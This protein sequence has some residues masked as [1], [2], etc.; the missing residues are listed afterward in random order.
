MLTE[1][2]LAVARLCRFAWWSFCFLVA[3]SSWLDASAMGLALPLILCLILN[4][5]LFGFG[6]CFTLLWFVSLCSERMLPSSFFCFWGMPHASC[7][8]INNATLAETTRGSGCGNRNSPRSL[9]ILFSWLPRAGD[10]ATERQFTM[11]STQQHAINHSPTQRSVSSPLT[12]GLSCP[13][14]PSA[15]LHQTCQRRCQTA[16]G[17]STFGFH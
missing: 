11:W 13:A 15:S 8:C 9:S 5:S 17:C 4:L 3:W 7:R 1:L 2:L 10:A 14:L 12:P 16:S 6:V